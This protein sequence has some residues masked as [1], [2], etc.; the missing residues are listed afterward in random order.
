MYIPYFVLNE[1]DLNNEKVLENISHFALIPGVLNADI[2]IVQSEKMREAYI[3]VL[4][5]YAGAEER[6]Y[7]AKKIKGSGSPKFTSILCK[8]GEEMDIPEEWRQLCYNRHGIR[9]A[10]ILYNTSVG[11]FL[12]HE[13]QMIDKMRSVFLFFESH[14][15]EL[16]LLWRPHPLMEATIS[17]MRPE[18]W[19]E[20][21]AVVREYKEK[22]IGIFDDTPEVGRAIVLCDAY[23]G[24]PS[25]L[26]RLCQK[27]KKPVMI[28]NVDKL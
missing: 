19:D 3:E 4:A 13:K 18:L 15:D 1:P 14:K 7:W 24:D 10:L 16:L 6:E 28:Q 25:S 22:E 2:V 21:Q 17:A 27:A 12:A 26:V 23:Y 11:S 8:S 20:Y 5:R 9:R